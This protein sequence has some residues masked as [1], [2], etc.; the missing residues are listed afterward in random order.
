MRRTLVGLCCGAVLCPLYADRLIEIPTGNLLYPERLAIE[1]GVLQGKPVRERVLMSFR[2]GDWV[3][4][5]GARMGFENRLEVYGLQYSLYPE[6]PGYA[7]GISVGVW[8]VFGRTAQGRG[9]FVAVSYGIAALG[10]TPLD[11]DLRVHLG[12]GWGGMPSLFVGFDIPLTNQLFLRAE[13]TGA[14][15]NAALAWRPREQVEVRG[16]V[17][18]GQTS[19]SIMIRL[20]AE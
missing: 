3:E 11:R 7:P 19:W 6:I 10:Q 4:V 16:A 9:Y 8:D 2:L 13:H 1:A 12:F 17:V 18:R 15:I 14:Q 20:W 5:Q